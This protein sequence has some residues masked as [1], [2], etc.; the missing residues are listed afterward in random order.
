MD[1]PIQVSRFDPAKIKKRVIFPI[2][3]SLGSMAF[4]FSFTSFRGISIEEIE[5]TRFHFPFL[6]MALCVLC[7]TWMVDGLRVYLTARAWDKKIS[8]RSALAAV[9]SQYFMSSITPFMTGGSPAQLYVL[10]QSG[11]G[12]GEASS[13]VVICGILYQASLLLLLF[14][15]VFFFRVGFTLRG[16]LLGVLYS[17]A[18]FY[19]VVMF[20]LFFFLYHPSALFRATNWGISFVRRHFKRAKFSEEAVRKWIEEFLE[21][22]R[23]GFAILFRK[24]PQYLAWNLGCYMFNYTLIFSLAYL[25]IRALG[26]SPPILRVIGVQIPLF[27]IFSF[28][29]SPGASGGAEVSL[30]SVFSGLVGI[31]K[32]GMFVL[33]WRSFTFYLP[34]LVGGIVFFRVLRGVSGR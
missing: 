2:L 16:V 4:I 30:A 26:S 22:F 8:F 23:E 14:V 10:A 9:L 13:L 29:P 24:K 15:F 33:L 7:V 18:I 17:F 34:M 27:Y 5:K 28:I 20:L 1:N 32:V 19:S 6:G 11:L 21:E 12:W 25:V 3:I 31:H